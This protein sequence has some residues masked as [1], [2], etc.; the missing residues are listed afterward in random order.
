MNPIKEVT[1]DIND[2]F[3]DFKKMYAKPYNKNTT[4]P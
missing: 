3:I 4:S 2:Y 1:N